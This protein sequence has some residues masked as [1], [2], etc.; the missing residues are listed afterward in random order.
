MNAIEVFGDVVCPFTHAGLRRLVAARSKVGSTRRLWIRAWPLE[1]VNGR[2]LAASHVALEVDALRETVAP[3][4]FRKFDPSAFPQTSIPAFGLAAAAYAV[5]DLTGESVSLAL[6]DALFE[7]G[8]DIS[9]AGVLREIASEF[10]VSMPSADVAEAAVRAD[11]NEGKARGVMG[12]PHFF[13]GERDW[14]CPALDIK[15]VHGHFEVKPRPEAERFF[16]TVL[17]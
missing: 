14:F 9:D 6:R 16:E 3:H 11:W 8:L 13:D 1:W 15:N 12:S 2:P 17:S 4:L 10:A 5:D 7:R